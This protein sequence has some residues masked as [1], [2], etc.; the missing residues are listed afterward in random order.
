M[1]GENYLTKVR[2]L[3][4]FCQNTEGAAFAEFNVPKIDFVKK[5]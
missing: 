4:F 3:T 1:N 5:V 2:F